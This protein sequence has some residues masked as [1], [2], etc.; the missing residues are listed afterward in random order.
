MIGKPHSFTPDID[1]LLKKTLDELS[2]ACYNDDAIVASVSAKK[3]YGEVAK[4]IFFF[5]DII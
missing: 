4:T 5:E 3:I 2:K 1:N